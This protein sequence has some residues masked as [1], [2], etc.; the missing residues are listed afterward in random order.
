MISDFAER[1]H[2]YQWFGECALS[3]GIEGA[4]WR[5]SVRWTGN[6]TSRFVNAQFIFISHINLISKWKKSPW[7]FRLT[8]YSG[9]RALHCSLVFLMKSGI[10]LDC[11]S[12]CLWS[13]DPY[14]LSLSLSSDLPIRKIATLM[15]DPT[16]FGLDYLRSLGHG[17]STV[18]SPIHMLIT[19]SLFHLHGNDYHNHSLPMFKGLSED[20]ARKLWERWS[21]E[22]MNLNGEWPVSFTERMSKFQPF[23]ARKH[24]RKAFR[25]LW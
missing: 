14:H 15:I 18:F 4:T 7:R 25:K 6:D 12:C 2:S 13:H 9:W 17:E 19:L 22:M 21:F 24:N 23:S 11:A 16:T 8:H 10:S 3:F 20:E 5:W 1:S